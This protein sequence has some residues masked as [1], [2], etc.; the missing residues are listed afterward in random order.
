VKPLFGD[1]KKKADDINKLGHYGT[2]A[3]P[4][5]MTIPTA[6]SFNQ[7]VTLG[8]KEKRLRYLQ[9]YW[10]TKA[11]K[12]DRVKV[13]TP[14]SKEQSCAL[15]SFKVEGME[16]ARLVQR[17]DEEFN[18]FTVIRRLKDDT[19]IRVTPNLYNTTDD[20]DRLLEGLAV[21]SKS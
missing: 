1:S 12:I 20:L 15:A 4:I 8:T 14:Q 11:S 3:T 5:V 19:V 2:P 7:M 18:V 6:G 9:N 10:T 17:L 21:I 13:T 16:S